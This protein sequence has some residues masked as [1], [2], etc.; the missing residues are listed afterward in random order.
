MNV[1][2]VFDGMSVGRIALKK[3]GIHVDN[4]FASEVD[5]YAIKVSKANWDDIN[6]VG[7]VCLLKADTLPKIDL[8][9]GGSPC[10]SFSVAGDGSG[11]DGSSKL[12]WEYVRLLKELREIN[13]D[14]LFLLENV[15]MKQEWRDV[16]SDALGVKPI[17]INS[18]HF[19]P[20]NRP[21][22]FWTNISVSQ[23]TFKTTRVLA[24]ILERRP[25]AKYFL[26]EKAKSYMSRERNKGKSRWEF[27]RNPLNGH[28]SCL[29]ANMYKGVPY[30]VIKDLQRRL[31]P[32]ECERLQG[33]P[34]GYTDHV[35]ATQRLKMLGNGWTVD[36]I[37]FIFMH[38]E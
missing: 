35:S 10:Q 7:D 22:L 6:H 16:I 17:L 28:A 34:D 5:E 1:L 8:F 30:G 31:T 29:T 33:V 23:P 20:Q 14:V 19:V 21:R 24:E 12:F 25:D 37:D 36:T 9:I 11:F 2:S 32:M 27:H 4:Y 38:I 15:K 3:A 26:S 18:N 13:P